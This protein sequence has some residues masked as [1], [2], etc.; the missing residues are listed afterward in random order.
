MVGVQPRPHQ[1]FLRLLADH[2]CIRGFTNFNLLTQFLLK[3]MPSLQQLLQLR[4][5]GTEPVPCRDCGSSSNSAVSRTNCSAKNSNGS[6][7]SDAKGESSIFCSHTSFP[8]SNSN[9]AAQFPLMQDLSQL[10]AH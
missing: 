7:N 10:Q 2:Q 6:C 8:I 4:H 9:S 1:L 3:M 5:Q